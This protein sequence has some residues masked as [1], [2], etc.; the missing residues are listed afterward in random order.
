MIEELSWVRDG[1]SIRE[2]EGVEG[3][4]RLAL[5]GGNQ[6]FELMQR[7]FVMQG[8]NR[9]AMEGIGSIGNLAKREPKVFNRIMAYPNISDE[10]LISLAE[11]GR[12]DVEPEI[13][14]RVM[15]HP[16]ISD[17]IDDDEAKVLTVLAS[18][19]DDN[20]ALVDVLLDVEQVQFERRSITLPLTGEVELTMIRTLPGVEGHMDLLERA[21][22]A[23]E[24]FMSMPFPQRQVI[25]LFLDGYDGAGSNSGTHATSN[26]A[27]Y[28]VE[29]PVKSPFRH[30][31]HESSHWYWGGSSSGWIDEGAPTFLEAVIEARTHGWPIAMER[32]PCPSAKSIVDD[33]EEECDY[34][35]GERLFHDLH[36]SMNETDFRL[37][38]GVYI[39]CLSMTI[40][41]TNVVAPTGK[42]VTL[43]PHS[44]TVPLRMRQRG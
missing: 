34:R 18:A 35:F 10:T 3:L 19:Q 33:E 12:E 40:P 4:I 17:G 13:I 14:D 44:P 23:I 6:F 26:P 28:D 5:F 8:T 21:V 15:S 41:T 7:P 39:F 22:R 29:T 24:E 31:I 32:Q 38:S 9:A 2:V 30:F 37:G 11:L 1:I 27:Y 16:N 25:W 20:P 36:R 42:S 43:R